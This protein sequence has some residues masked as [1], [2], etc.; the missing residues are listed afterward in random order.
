VERSETGTTHFWLCD[1]ACNESSSRQPTGPPILE[2]PI[3]TSSNRDALLITTR[4]SPK[5]CHLFAGHSA[6]ALHMAS[7]ALVTVSK[8]MT[9]NRQLKLSIANPSEAL[10]LHTT[11]LTGKQ[12]ECLSRCAKGISIR[13]EGSEIVDA[14]VAGGYAEQGVAGV[15]TV[16][17]K[18]QQY[19]RTPPS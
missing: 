19:L 16:T 13:F 1:R 2:S 3:V 18:G 6:H 7:S 15:V 9:H 12:L 5:K 4:S 14:L 11:R 8:D 10:A 17:A